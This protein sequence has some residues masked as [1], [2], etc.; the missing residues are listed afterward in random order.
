MQLSGIVTPTSDTSANQV[1]PFTLT[2]LQNPIK[3]TVSNI[4]ATNMATYQNN[5]FISGA[6]LTIK[7]DAAFL[8]KLPFVTLWGNN[9]NAL[10]TT[11][12]M[13]LNKYT[14]TVDWNDGTST[15]G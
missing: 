9:P 14:L 11:T 12:D 15:Y 7:A 2:Q 3:A 8:A 1:K 6:N 10:K 4:D 13:N 5:F